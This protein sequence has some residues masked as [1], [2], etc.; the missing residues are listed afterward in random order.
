MHLSKFHE[1]RA[2]HKFQRI[3][4]AVT[5][6]KTNTENWSYRF[7]G[8]GAWY[9][10]ELV[11]VIREKFITSCGYFLHTSEMLFS[12]RLCLKIVGV[13]WYSLMMIMASGVS[14]W[15]AYIHYR[16]SGK[17]GMPDT[18]TKLKSKHF[19]FRIPLSILIWFLRISPKYHT[20][21]AKRGSARLWVV[22]YTFQSYILYVYTSTICD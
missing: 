6:S 4:I 17:T 9:F 16:N 10:P 22:P 8:K 7:K 21:L 2:F 20:Y 18:S 13:R 12:L 3:F 11:F 15:P 5:S 1:Q 14:V 19:F